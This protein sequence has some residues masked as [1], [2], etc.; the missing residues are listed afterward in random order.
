VQ[1]YQIAAK[2]LIQLKS[3]SFKRCVALKM[4]AT[5]EHSIKQRNELIF[6]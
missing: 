1:P 6:I 2:N 5:I 3:C 4:M